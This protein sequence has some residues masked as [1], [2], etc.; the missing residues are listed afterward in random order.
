MKGH[1]L[2]QNVDLLEELFG[3]ERALGI[4][5]RLNPEFRAALESGSLTRAGWYP[6]AWANELHEASVREITGV[7]DIPERVARRGVERD[8]AGIYGFLARMV[9]PEFCIKQSPRI[10]STYFRGMTIET[11][12]VTSG[13]AILTFRGCSGIG[14]LLWRDILAGSG[15]IFEAA[16][17][18][19]VVLRSK[20]G[21]RES[22]SEH[23]VE[24]RWT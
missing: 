7:S 5:A 8:M 1:A 13:T 17:A 2:R 14:R 4:V 9:T 3:A 24:V 20:E 6:A 15:R 18:K 12:E 21:G 23:V 22:D 11:S 10:L 16:G 19:N